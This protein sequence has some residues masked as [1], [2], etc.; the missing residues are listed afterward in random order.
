MKFQLRALWMVLSFF[1]GAFAWAGVSYEDYEFLRQR[2][3][4]VFSPLVAERGYTLHASDR[5][6]SLSD[7]AGAER[8]YKNWSIWVPGGLAKHEAIDFHGLATF[9]CHEMGHHLG[10]VPYKSKFYASTW[11]SSE[12]QA[13]YFASAKCF[14]VLFT[15]Q[16][17]LSWWEANEAHVPQTIRNLCQEA[18]SGLP[19]VISC[20]RGIL[21]GL[22][23]SHF[24]N[25]KA[26]KRPN[27]QIE[28]PSAKV[29]KKTTWKH[30]KP[31]C[32]LDTY[33]A[34]AL[35]GA[36]QKNSTVAWDD[37]EGFC[38]GLSGFGQRPTCWY[39]S[40]AAVQ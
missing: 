20:V 33:I 30:T 32:R 18:H 34:G 5:W 37:N 15:P 35:C 25:R 4:E 28:T 17:H 29:V 14:S 16:E 36:F 9:F 2:T 6:G 26:K 40:P 22:S 11:A 24:L 39:K 8:A 21:G 23:A 19:R 1:S 27:P 10:G 31:Q 3:L 7:L 13:D 38:D 12:G